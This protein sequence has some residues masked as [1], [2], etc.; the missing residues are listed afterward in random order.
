MN[1][2][3]Q[4]IEDIVVFSLNETKLDANNSGLVKA[5]FT[6]LMKLESVKKLILDLTDVETCDSTG[7]SA[8]LVANR[9]VNANN[10]AVCLVSTSEKVLSLIRITQLN[11]VLGVHTTLA[12]A[13]QELK[14]K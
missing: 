14:N 9:L 2:T 8:L 4:R 6:L 11:K 1:F 7:L 12:E 10:G 5:E 3:T 13:L